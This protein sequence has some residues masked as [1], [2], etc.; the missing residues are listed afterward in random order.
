MDAFFLS[1]T[2]LRRPGNSAGNGVLRQRLGRALVFSLC[3]CFFLAAF[4]GAGCAKQTPDPLEPTPRELARR[5]DPSG[6]KLSPEAEHLYY[7]L[8]LSQG[9]ADN[10]QPVITLA[11]QGLLRLDP[12]LPV[13]QDSAT[14]FLAR[15]EHEAAEQTA[16]EGL[17]RYPEDSVLTLLLAGAY[18]ENNKREKAVALLETFLQNHPQAHTVMEELVRL[19][20]KDGQEQRASDWLARLPESSRSLETELFRAGVLSTVGRNAEARAVLRGLIGKE[21]ER[22]EPW[23]ELA[24]LAEREKNAA[25]AIEAYSKAAELL[26]D[27]AEVR[28]RIAALHIKQKAPDQAEA[29][30]AGAEPSAPLF[31]QAALNFAD[32]GYYDAAERMLVKAEQ[33]GAS[34]DELALFRSMLKQERS[35]DPKAGLP[36]LESIARE[37]PLYASAL[38]QK[39]RIYLLAK[40]YAKARSTA[41]EGRT[42]FPDKKELWGLEAYALVKMRKGED[43]EKLLKEALQRY[44]GDEDLLFSL[45][46]VQDEAGKKNAA[47]K[48]MEQIIAVNPKH[49]QAMNYVGYTLAENNRELTRALTL[50]S[51]ALEQNPDAD[52]I[53]DSLAWVQY[54][55]GRHEEAWKTIN[56]CISLGGDDATIWEH[57]GDIA[58]ALGKK[59]EAVKG[60]SESIRREPDN[61][62]DVRRK[63]SAAEQ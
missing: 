25:E 8:V 22:F 48:T 38:Q 40:D 59:D 44:P 11:L 9:L 60:Y 1:R 15:G 16:R 61:I 53:V 17:R 50:I 7:Y 32:G 12:A 28:F 62:A 63:L 36:P 47:M 26:P 33:N 6:W 37:S 43:A 31:I 2:G 20:L 23:L 4:C 58:M 56:R 49:Y 24:Y 21:P 14:I 5:I 19:L 51:S 29:A 34:P 52:Y 55:L 57:Y 18:S 54:R 42:Q 3:L 13:Y 46:G 30:I 41:R 10:S 35:G 27:N 45:G 39:A